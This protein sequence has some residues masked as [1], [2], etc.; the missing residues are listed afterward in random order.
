MSEEGKK[1]KKDYRTMI[2]ARAKQSK[3]LRHIVA[4]KAPEG[5][6]KERG[7]RQIVKLEKEKKKADR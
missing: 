2:R 1:E 4:E 5:K 3:G 6:T 7:L